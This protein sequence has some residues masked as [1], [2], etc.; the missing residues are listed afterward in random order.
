MEF[1]L[2]DCI[3]GL[4]YVIIF[5][6]HI[7][8]LCYRSILREHVTES[9]HAMILWNYITESSLWKGPRGC[10]GRPRSPLGSQGY[11]GH[12]PGT[13]PGT[14]L[15]PPGT[16]RDPLWLTKTA[17]SP[18]IYSARS[19]DCYVETC[20][21][22]PVAWRTPPDRFIYKKVAKVKNT[23]PGP[24]T[25]RRR[26]R[27]RPDPCGVLIQGYIYIYIYIYHMIIYDR[28]CT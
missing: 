22:G 19:F 15:R 20:L 23:T 27:L 9:Y 7:T 3:T 4:Y 28:V 25:F 8:G 24:V 26:I 5:R 18:H 16:S 2:R 6:N 21:L 17:I 13:P 14:P 12:T 1:T 10:L 11:P